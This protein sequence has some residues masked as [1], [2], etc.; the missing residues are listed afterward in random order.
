MDAAGHIQKVNIGYLIYINFIF[1]IKNFKNLKTCFTKK[2]FSFISMCQ[3]DIEWF[4]FDNQTCEMK[5]GRSYIKIILYKNQNKTK[6]PTGSWTYGGN[7]VDLMHK[8]EQ[9]QVKR[10]EVAAVTNGW[11]ERLIFYLEDGRDFRS[12]I[13]I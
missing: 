1:I 8:D 5:F 3:I 11:N 10:H 9:K 4:P 2:L 13:Q 7:E 6:K 12:K